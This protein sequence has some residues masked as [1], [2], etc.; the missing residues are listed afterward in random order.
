MN[1]S[2]R[3]TS[4]MPAPEGLWR[5]TRGA[6]TL[7]FGLMLMVYVVILFGLLVVHE[8][9]LVTKRVQ[10]EARVIAW[11]SLCSGEV[12]VEGIRT[13]LQKHHPGDLLEATVEVPPFDPST[14]T[15]VEDNSSDTAVKVLQT[16]CRRMEGRVN[17]GFRSPWKLGWPG[18]GDLEGSWDVER[19]HLVVTRAQ[20]MFMPARVLPVVVDPD[21][22][23]DD[24]GDGGGERP[25]P[26]EKDPTLTP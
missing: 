7:E 1:D 3:P 15:E 24:P 16:V 19:R 12:N 14:V 9:G 4:T 25:P 26:E 13:R 20:V 21:G 11:N 8:M 2:A 23:V 6:S 17:F 10:T 18:D 5:D 22:D